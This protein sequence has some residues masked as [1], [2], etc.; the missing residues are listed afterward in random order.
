MVQSLNKKWKEFLFS[1]SGFGPNFLMVLMGAYYTDA[2]NPVA[3]EGNSEYQA[4]AGGICFIVPALFPILFALGKVFD[5]IIDVPFAHITDTLSTKWGR[6]RP[7]IA[8]CFIP[9]VVSFVLSWIPVGGAE[10]PLFNTIWVAIWNVVFF[11]AYTMCMIAYYGSLTTVCTN[12]P[13]RLRVSGYKSF[14]DTISYCLVYALVPLLLDSFAVH[15]DEFVFFCTPL[16]ATML[17]PLFMIKEGKKYGYPEDEGLQ[18][19]KLS[20]IESVKL[21]FKNKIFL[22]WT[23]VNCCTFFGLQMF[24]SGMNGMI[25]GGMSFN[26]LE[27]AIINTCAFAPVPIM[28]YLFNKLKAKR[29]VRFTYQSCLLLFAVAIM[30][31]FLASTYVCGHDN[32]MLQYIIGCIGG[33]CGSWSIGAFFMMPY[34]APAQIA[35][36]ETE[37]TGKNHSAMYFAA[38]AVTTSIVG[39]IS[40]SL[41]YEYIKNL[42]ISKSA[43]GVVWAQ[44]VE[45]AAQSFGLGAD[46]LQVYNLGNLLVPFI[47]CITCVAGFFIATKMPR[48]YT[49]E[50]LAKEFKKMDP[51]LDISAYEGQTT[52]EEK[53]EIIFV[54][55]GL[56]ILSGFLFGFVWLSF[57]LGSIK[58]LTGKGCTAVRWLLGSL[59]P[60][61]AIYVLLRARADLLGAAKEKGI[62]L[63]IPAWLLVASGLILPILPVNILAQAILQHAV[64]K[65]YESER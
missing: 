23:F 39:A 36:M 42:F 56:S 1:F 52:P 24:L 17:I 2:L 40:G 34:L 58:R 53:G 29:G 37:L 64:N 31:F 43:S 11:A 50:I 48:D 44:S 60:F 57:L 21:T 33:I 32:K 10:N 38:N 9:M 19:Q 14:F 63:S 22:N 12:E 30:S 41:V 65:L 47:V 45:E 3:L 61:A 46:S 4:I 27:M 13:Q 28:L 15:V 62:R 18:A 7:A 59:I 49:P 54:Q 26:G 51:S 8:V 35:S 16:M 5:G 25:I 20:I 6:R 55:V